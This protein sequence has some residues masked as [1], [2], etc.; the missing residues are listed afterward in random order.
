MRPGSQS[1]YLQSESLSSRPNK[2]YRLAQAGPVIM[3]DDYVLHL[4]P[5]A[6]NQTIVHRASLPGALQIPS[7]AV[8]AITSDAMVELPQASVRRTFDP[9][10]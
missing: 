9:G 7:S 6:S 4:R 5:R 3:V 1:S 10:G 2:H 8:S